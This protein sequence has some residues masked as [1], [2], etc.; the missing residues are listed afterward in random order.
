[1]TSHF[2]TIFSVSCVLLGAAFGCPEGAFQDPDDSDYC[3]TVHK[4]L[5]PWWTALSVCNFE[6]GNLV[7]VH[8][9]RTNRFLKKLGE[10]WMDDSFMWI[11]ANNYIVGGSTWSWQDGTPFDFT[12][13]GR[14]EPSAKNQG[15]GCALFFIGNERCKLVVDHSVSIQ[16]VAAQCVFIDVLV[17]DHLNPLE[18]VIFVFA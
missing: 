1:M 12:R 6:G 5:Q 17:V 8:D 15:N 4:E 14:G 3:F 13:W 11:G 16:L 18:L 9:S 7:S 10:K 2:L